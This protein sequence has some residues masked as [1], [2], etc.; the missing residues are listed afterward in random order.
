MQMKST[1]SECFY[2]AAA[3]SLGLSIGCLISSCLIVRA[4]SDDVSKLYWE[5]LKGELGFAIISVVFYC[6]G[7]MGKKSQ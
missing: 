2:V 7:R 3:I 5:L 6:M 4:T 1:T